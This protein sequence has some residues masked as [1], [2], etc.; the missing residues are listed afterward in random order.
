M[1]SGHFGIEQVI[2]EDRAYSGSRFSEVRA[3][4]F[5]NPHQEVW[6]REGTA[7]L[8]CYETKLSNVLR[9]ILPFGQPYLFRQAAER[10]VDS[11]SVSRGL[12]LPIDSTH[13]T[14]FE[15]QAEIGARVPVVGKA[16]KKTTGW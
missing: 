7:P 6:G 14:L 5:A 2:E 8:P 16:N 3:A 12:R 1:E 4:I 13:G 11:T 15:R 9:R 10:A